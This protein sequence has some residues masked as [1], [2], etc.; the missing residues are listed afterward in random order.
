MRIIK[1]FPLIGILMLLLFSVSVYAKE[2]D[3][4]SFTYEVVAADSK[5]EARKILEANGY[6]LIDKNV[7]DYEDAISDKA[8]YVG[9]R[10]VDEAQADKAGAYSASAFGKSSIV[11]IGGTGVVVGVMIG[12]LSMKYKKITKENADET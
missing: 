10:I 12:M 4:D 11:M 6:T 8:V 7:A 3:R 5:E 9:Y 2:T 1:M